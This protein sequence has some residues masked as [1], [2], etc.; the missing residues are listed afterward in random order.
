ML[1]KYNARSTIS[2]NSKGSAHTEQ[3]KGLND[4]YEKRNRQQNCHKLYAVI[5]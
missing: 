4:R 2:S 1:L 5:N 3:I